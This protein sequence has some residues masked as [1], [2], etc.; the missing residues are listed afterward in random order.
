MC[1]KNIILFIDELHSIVGTGAAEGA[2]DAA[3]IRKAQLA[4]GE[5]CPIGATPTEE[6]RRFIEKASALER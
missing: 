1:G 4:R 3:N 5:I 6:Y 2:I